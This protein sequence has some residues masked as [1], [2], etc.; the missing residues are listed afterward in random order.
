MNQKYVHE[1]EIELK[2]LESNFASL[3]QRC[4]LAESGRDTKERELE[5]IAG[6]VPYLEAVVNEKDNDLQKPLFEFAGL[7]QL[8]GL[9]MKKRAD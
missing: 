9:V 6:K 1:L 3:G 4:Q 5:N 2:K 8:L 7:E